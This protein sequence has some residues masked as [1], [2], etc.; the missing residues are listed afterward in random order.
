MNDPDLDELEHQLLA[1]RERRLRLHG[2][3]T[4]GAWIVSILVII[5][6]AI[7]IAIARFA[8]DVAVIRYVMG[9]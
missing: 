2:A 5:V 7:G 3:L 6:V 1:N 9:W 8:F 4:S